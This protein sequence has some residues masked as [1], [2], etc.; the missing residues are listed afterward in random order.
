MFNYK[1]IF[2]NGLH[3]NMLTRLLF[4]CFVIIIF[5]CNR[6]A[7]SFLSSAAFNK[8]LDSVSNMN[9]GGKKE[10]AIHYLDSAYRHSKNL[11]LLQT[12][13][14]Y[15]FNYNYFYSVKADKNTSLLYAD[16]MLSLF[17]TPDKK[18]KYATE[19]GQ[20]YFYKGDVL[21]DQ[22]RYNEAYEN[23]YHGKIIGNNNL[24]ECV[25][26]DYSYRMGMIMYKQEHYRLAAAYFKNSAKESAACAGNFGAFY[27]TQELTDNIGLS[28]SAVNLTDSALFFYNKALDYIDQHQIQYRDRREMLDV[29]RGVIYGNLA[30]V[31]IGLKKY[32]QAK[33]LLK[34]SIRINLRKGNDNQDAQYAEL[35][36]AAVYNNLNQADSLLNI[37]NVI[38][39]QFEYLHQQDARADWNYLMSEYLVKKSKPDEAIKYFIQYDALKDSINQKNKALKEADI[40]EQIKRLEKDNEFDKLKK[41]N[42]QQNIYLNVTIVF[43]VML[44]M[45]ISLVFLNWQKSKKNI[46]TLG[47]LNQQINEQ[48]T[49]LEH[50]LNELK[51]NSQEKDR[52]LRTVAHDL[53]NP[54]G[55]IAS[56][57]S[58]MGE[59]DYTDEQKEM[60]NLI[61]ETS[62]NSLELINEI[63]EA[64]NSTNTGLN[65][66]QVEI[67]GLLTN[68]VELLRFKAAEKS[69]TI[70]LELLPGPLEL[71]ISR[72]K[73]WRVV[74]NLISNAIKFSPAGAP[75]FVKVEV[76]EREV[77]IS[78]KDNGIGIPDKLKSQ[79]F[80]MFTDAKRPGTEGEKSFGLGLSICRQ[81][82]EKHNGRIWFQSDTEHGTTF[83]FSLPK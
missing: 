17:N 57:T 71:M 23:F 47:R 18:S 72:E 70:S 30:N 27:R 43:V 28:Y 9:D 61:K 21:F 79:V 12:Y 3:I 25:L 62:F 50:A 6:A 10:E 1:S 2:R 59:D 64:T 4:I 58:V 74:S 52:I 40:A 24:D 68:S 55:G 19:Y 73:I 65:L 13:S 15:R 76:F 77:Q 14:Y 53:R 42:Q 80:N 49:H 46:Q 37:L 63:L 5:S 22:N 83:Y 29:A 81:I 75:I 7:N 34:K 60:L 82:I 20:S 39:K 11:N 26:S 67:N 38:K 66:E 8:V 78:V 35:K 32:S 45:I 31:Y 56:L 48:N 36:L 16:S 41:N 33:T 54:I 69:Q 44:V 51:L